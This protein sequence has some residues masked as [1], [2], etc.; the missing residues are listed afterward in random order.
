MATIGASAAAASSAAPCSSARRPHSVARTVFALRDP[1]HPVARTSPT[2]AFDVFT[3]RASSSCSSQQRVPK[4]SPC[5]VQTYD[6][7]KNL[8]K[9]SASARAVEEGDVAADQLRLVALALNAAERPHRRHHRQH[10]E[11]ALQSHDSVLR[12][13][14]SYHGQTCARWP[15]TAYRAAQQRRSVTSDAG[16]L[17]DSAMHARLD[18]HPVRWR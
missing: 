17:K 4:P 18:V 6:G 3:W 12:M 15:T 8:G 11:Q 13:C 10:V 1:R 16:R 7:A 2:G 5:S 14:P 9:G